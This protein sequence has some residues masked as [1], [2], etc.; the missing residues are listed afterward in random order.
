MELARALK[1]A[2]EACAGWADEAPLAA[3]HAALLAPWRVVVVGRVA[4]G[5]STLV[6]RIVDRSVQAV[7]LGG[8]TTE[9]FE[10]PL[11]GVVLVDTPG[12]DDPDRA[13][14]ALSAPLQDAD[15]VIWVVDGL[16]PATASERAVLDGC[17]EPGVPLVAVVSKVDL[18]PDSEVSAVVRRVEH[19]GARWGVQRVVAVD[20]KDPASAVRALELAEPALPGPRRARLIGAALQEV[21][22]ALAEVDAPVDGADL[23][24][25]WTEAVRAAAAEVDEAIEAGRIQHKTDALA[26]LGKRAPAVMAAIRASLGPF[27]PPRLPAPEPPSDTGMGQMLAGLSGQEGARRMVKAG[28][29]R[30]LAEGQI[31]LQEWWAT[32]DDARHRTEGY[33]ELR[34]RLREVLEMTLEEG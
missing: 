2:M 34:A 15:A 14:V 25:A 30:W 32:A 9:L 12:I 13:L 16:Q 23:V 6:N 29:A 8:V 1:S 3:A 28:A 4:A 10:V 21:E 22:E 18:V 7:G 24:W 11:E 33:R 20:L 5:K 31:A 17:L 19:I 27:A 26:A